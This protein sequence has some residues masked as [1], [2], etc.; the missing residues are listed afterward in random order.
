MSSSFCLWLAGPLADMCNIVS[1]SQAPCQRGRG[2]AKREKLRAGTAEASRFG[3]AVPNRHSL[4][5][6]PAQVQRLQG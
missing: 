6:Q 4:K 2:I 1:I 3:T 5:E